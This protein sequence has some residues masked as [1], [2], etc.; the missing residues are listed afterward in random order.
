M[1]ITSTWKVVPDTFGDTFLLNINTKVGPY[2]MNCEM[3][4]IEHTITLNQTVMLI[5]SENPHSTFVAFRFNQNYIYRH[6]GRSTYRRDSIC[7]WRGEALKG[8]EIGIQLILQVSNVIK[9][10]IET[11][12]GGNSYMVG[13]PLETQY[14]N[15]YFQ[16]AKVNQWTNGVVESCLARWNLNTFPQ[17]YNFYS[18]PHEASE[19]IQVH[20][21]LCHHA[22]ATIVLE[23][24]R[25][26]S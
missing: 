14:Q 11:T 8:F 9:E 21:D 25:T 3:I 26:S 20:R 23:L 19:A 7:S 13:Q 6:H 18:Q 2:E 22:G 12:I 4:A 17:S 1:P 15:Q 5:T 10:A 16:H 24:R